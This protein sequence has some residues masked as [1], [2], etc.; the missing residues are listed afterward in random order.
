MKKYFLRTASLLIVILMLVPCLASCSTAAKLLRM[1]EPKRADAFFDIISNP[2]AAALKTESK[3]TLDGTLYEQRLE[4]AVES[5]AYTAVAEDGG[6]IQHIENKS[7]VRIGIDQKVIEVERGYRNG[8]MYEKISLV[9]EKKNTALSQEM[10]ADEYK[11]ILADSSGLS[12]GEIADLHKSATVKEC[13][14]NEDGSWYASFSGFPEDSIVALVKYASD[15]TVLMLDG[16][17]VKDIVMTAKADAEL[18]PTEWEYNIV[19]DYTATD[20]NYT[21]PKAHTVIKFSAVTAA[22]IPEADLSDCKEI[23]GY[24]VLNRLRRQ[25]GEYLY[26][27]ELYFTATSRQSISGNSVTETDVVS[28]CPDDGEYAFDID[29][30]Q[31]ATGSAAAVNIKMRYEDGRM[32]STQLGSTVGTKEMSETLARAFI[33]SLVDPAGLSSAAVSNISIYENRYTFTLAAPEYSALESSLLGQG[34]KDIKATAKVVVTMD[35]D[36]MDEYRYTLT[37]RGTY[38]NTTISVNVS[39]TVKIDSAE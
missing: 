13:K 34:V 7:D 35:G 39:S 15:P 12:D 9:R 20:K 32:V 6:F 29:A 22:D 16:A 19:F 14:Q 3:L 5:V 25:F 28:V 24:E 11:Q 2:Q 4:G 33:Y 17:T 1:D 38:A 26:A 10:T 30:T 21:E 23:K 8:K 27:D 37:V 36:K 31:T 18:M